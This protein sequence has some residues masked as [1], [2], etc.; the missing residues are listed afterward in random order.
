MRTILVFPDFGNEKLLEEI[1][2]NLADKI[3]QMDRIIDIKLD[4]YPSVKDYYW[5]I[6]ADTNNPKPSPSYINATCYDD[7]KC[8]DIINNKNYNILSE[9]L[10][11]AITS[12]NQ[13]IINIYEDYKKHKIFIKENNTIDFIKEKFINNQYEQL[14]INLNYVVISIEKRIYEAF[15]IDVSSLANKYNAIIEALNICAVIYCF[16]VEFITLTFIIFNLRKITKRI[17][18]AT[19]RIN[20]A[21]RYMIKKNINNDKEDN[22]SLIINSN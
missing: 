16:I 9:G 4:K 12:M 2:I 15:M 13:L 6:G 14:D 18:E 19:L 11:M 8:I 5:I 21:F 1:Q 7:Q 17:E 20:N 22:S 10:K 3:K